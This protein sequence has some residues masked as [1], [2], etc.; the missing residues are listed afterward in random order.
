MTSRRASY[1]HPFTD[2]DIICAAL[3]E[4]VHNYLILGDG[5]RV[6]IPRGPAAVKGTNPADATVLR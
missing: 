6:K 4:C 1:A 3:L 2:L 5:K